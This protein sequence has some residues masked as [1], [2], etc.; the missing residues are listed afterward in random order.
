MCATHTF[1]ELAHE[2][3]RIW[4]PTG[5]RCGTIRPA[6]RRGQSAACRPISPPLS[7]S[8]PVSPTPPVHPTGP[9]HH[10]EKRQGSQKGENHPE[11]LKDRYPHWTGDSARS[12]SQGLPFLASLVYLGQN[13][14]L[15]PYL[16]QM[17][18]KPRKNTKPKSLENG[19]FG[20]VRPGWHPARPRKSAP[21]RRI[22]VSRPP[23]SAPDKPERSPTQ[24]ITALTGAHA[25]ESAA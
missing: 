17:R 20:A 19:G 15:L 11:R 8:T 3:S 1:L 13:M 12:G 9:S 4:P 21:L 23:K 18:P 24:C 16:G 6:H 22:G 7:G 25:M 14:L 2:S 10:P 5:F